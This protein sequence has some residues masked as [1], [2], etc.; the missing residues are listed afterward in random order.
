MQ[1][2]T[3]TPLYISPPLGNP[4]KVPPSVFPTR[5]TASAARFWRSHHAPTHLTILVHHSDHRCARRRRQKQPK[6][7]GLGLGF[8]C[9]HPGTRRA[10]PHHARLQAAA[11][12][13]SQQRA[14][15]GFATAA[16]AESSF[17]SHPRPSP[18][19]AAHCRVANP[20]QTRRAAEPHHPATRRARQRSNPPR[21][22]PCIPSRRARPARKPASTAT[23]RPRLP[24]PAVPQLSL[25]PPAHRPASRRA[26]R[27][28]S[29]PAFAVA[30]R[31]P[32]HHQR[33]GRF[34]RRCGHRVPA[35]P[36]ARRRRESP[37]CRRQTSLRPVA[38][39][40]AA[41]SPPRLARGSAPPAPRGQRAHDS[42]RHDA[43][44]T[45]P[46]LAP[47]APQTG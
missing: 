38:A 27:E 9:F 21:P 41:R 16:L 22:S 24:L 13:A 40:P 14:E 20:R 6:H 44:A 26:S 31:W 7:L 3:V 33:D 4:E 10:A 15:H 39:S 18:P 45:R 23:H 11:S 25:T 17:A 19:R 46:R 5:S 2:I 37:T 1:G 12:S 43:P 35:P 32:R 29:V 42:R 30:C 28:N 47:P 36:G 8:C 34:A